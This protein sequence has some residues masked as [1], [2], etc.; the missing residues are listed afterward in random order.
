MLFRSTEVKVSAK[1]KNQFQSAYIQTRQI[2]THKANGTILTKIN[3]Q[4]LLAST[5]PDGYR[6]F[7]IRMFEAVLSIQFHRYLQ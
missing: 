4:D 1:T 6:L 5:L 3:L 2:I 7:W